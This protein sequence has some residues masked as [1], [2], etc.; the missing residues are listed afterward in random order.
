MSLDMLGQLN[1]LAVV[2]GAVFYY[3]LGAIWYAP[4]VL[5]RAWQRSI[6]WDPATPPPG[7]SAGTLVLPLLFYLVISAGIA[8]LAAA[9]GSA[10]VT[11]GLTLG[12]VLG[13]AFA[14]ARTAVDAVFDPNRPQRWTWFA[15]TAGYH[16]IAIV[17]IAVLVSVWV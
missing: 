4:P 13:L 2:V 9:T 14:V 1:W 3:V 12:V 7:M 16:F 15:I 5:G 11:G 17:G 6:G 8:M 10:D